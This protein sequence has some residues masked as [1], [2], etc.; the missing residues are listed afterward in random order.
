MI[1]ILKNIVPKKMIES[2]IETFQMKDRN[3][4]SRK[5][6][7]LTEG[8][9]FRRSMTSIKIDAPKE[10]VDLYLERNPLNLE[11]HR[12]VSR[13]SVYRSEEGFYSPHRDD[14]SVEKWAMVVAL[15]TLGKDYQDG[16]LYYITD[17]GYSNP[18]EYSMEA[19]DVAFFSPQ[20]T[21]GIA[22]IR[23]GDRYS[24][25]ITCEEIERLVLTQ[26]GR[27]IPAI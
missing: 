21:H 15:S 22:R 6:S 7:Y 23:G 27:W 13:L 4:M 5:D 26:D 20:L 19:G 8:V 25:L 16:G 2:L 3:G 17:F 10:L 12:V 14:S 18:I 9:K 1:E 24:L 11:T